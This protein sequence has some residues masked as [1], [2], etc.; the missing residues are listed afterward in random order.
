VKQHPQSFHGGECFTLVI[1]VLR[2]PGGKD[3]GGDPEIHVDDNGVWHDSITGCAIDS[4]Q[5]SFSFTAKRSGVVVLR[6][7]LI[8]GK[9]SS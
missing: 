4:G 3:I 5:D 7:S 8:A 6:A 2:G 1:G 9:S